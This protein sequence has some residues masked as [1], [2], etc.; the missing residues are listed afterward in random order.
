MRIFAP[1]ENAVHGAIDTPES[2]AAV[3]EVVELSGWVLLADGPPRTIE[4]FLGDVPLGQVV[5]EEP[6][7]A[8]SPADDTLGVE[9]WGFSAGFPIPDKAEGEMALRVRITDDQ[10]SGG[11]LR[12]PVR[13]SPCP[14]HA[15]LDAPHDNVETGRLIEVA[16]WA[17]SLQGSIISVQAFL[18]GDRLGKVPYGL[19]RPD[20]AKAR[21]G[22]S[23][24]AVGFEGRFVIDEGIRGWGDLKVL[25]EDDHGNRRELENKLFIPRDQVYLEIDTPRAGARFAGRI[26]I[27]GWAYRESS[28]IQRVEAWV[29]DEALGALPLG[30]ARPDVV[31]SLGRLAAARCGF[32][33]TREVLLAEPGPLTL[34][35]RAFGRSGCV[36]EREIEI[37]AVSPADPQCEIEKAKWQGNR[38]EVEG[39]GLWPPS[40]SARRVRV[41]VDG[42]LVGGSKANLSR[43]DLLRRFPSYGN[44][45]RCGFRFSALYAERTGDGPC[46][47]RVE[48]EARDG[49]MLSQS[50]LV[51]HEPRPGQAVVFQLY[52]ALREVLDRFRARWNRAPTILDWDTGLGV[53]SEHRDL[54][55]F[56]PPKTKRTDLPYA[57]RSIDLVIA[58]GGDPEVVEEAQRVADAAVLL[59]DGLA[60]ASSEADSS[61][62]RVVWLKGGEE[63]SGSA[64][65]P[66]SASIIIPVH[67][68]SDYTARCLERVLETLPRDLDVEIIVVD[69]ASTDDT[70]AILARFHD[71]DRRV[72]PLRCDHN[73]GFVGACN[74]GAGQAR[75]EVLVFLNNDTLPEERWLE[76]LVSFFPEHPDAGAVGGKLLFPDGILQEAGGV[77]FSDASG[78]NFGKFDEDPEAPLYN[79][80]REVDY[81]SGALLATPRQLFEELGGFD[82]RYAPAYYEDVDYCFSVRERG[83]KVYFEPE[84]VVIHFEGVSSGVDAHSGVKRYQ[85][86][87][88]I[89]FQEKWKAA[90]LRQSPPPD[91]FDMRLRC[92]VAVRRDTGSRE[93]TVGD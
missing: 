86:D 47:L 72:K 59:L 44:A 55:V 30:Y 35:V 63:A 89:K 79:H 45:R 29:G 52:P 27:G 9:R 67:N 49:R 14:I 1:S 2:H 42:E 8:L 19:P 34:T 18:N 74:L 20:V 22:Y 70:P 40:T 92:A 62:V 71:A 90:L 78:Y 73:R 64:G 4:V 50:V 76:P 68:H 32:W 77:I 69:D 84:S 21:P 82:D 16:G 83:L 66:P 6:S 7:P 28:P 23:H 51:T 25:I 61:A 75:G 31:E 81:C 85:L 17:V 80:V 53:E 26:V 38:L 43:P 10:G 54:V 93:A 24:A 13:V 12:C 33:V 39:W 58:W 46:E 57:S 56:R 88:R 91:E 48:W 5:A 11:E 41:F 60:L 37:N 15:H 65:D 87:N 3:S 36:D